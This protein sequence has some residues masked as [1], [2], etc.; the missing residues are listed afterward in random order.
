VTPLE[1]A[2]AGIACP[3]CGV[4]TP[5]EARFCPACGERLLGGGDDERRVVT[6]LFADLVESTR[7]VESLDPEAARDLLNE[8]FRRLAAEIRRCGGTLE[9]FVGDAIL[10]VFGFPTGHDDDAARAVR[11]SLAM[12]DIVK[13]AETA[14]GNLPLQLRIG[15][16]TGEVAAGRWSGDLRVTGPAVHTAARI[17]Q[18]AKPDQILLSARTLRA[19]RDIVEVGRPESLTVRGQGQ[20]VE[21]AEVL[22]LTPAE[23][24]SDPMVGREADLAGLIGA[25]DHAAHHN[26]LVLLVG[27]AG[28]G[29]STL[30]RAVAAEVGDRVHVLW[31]RCLPDWQSLPFWPIRE[32]LATAAGMAATE[33]AEVLTAAVGRLVADTWPDGSAA[34]ATAEALCRLAGLDPDDPDPPAQSGLGSSRE[35]AAAMAGVLCGLAGR[36]RVLV[37]LEDLHWATSDLLE[38]ASTL[39]GDGCR[40]QG[41]L[42]YLGISRP[43]LLGLPAWLLRT[44][45]QRIDLEP[46]G[47]EPAGEL[48]GSVLGADAAPELAGQ[49]FEASRGNPLFVKELAL[50]LREAGP[51]EP[52]QSS[53]PIPDSLQALVAARL[54]RLPPSAKRVLCRAA[55]VGKWFSHAALA[56]MAQ[57]GDGRLDSD[58]DR[59]VQEGLIERLPERLAGGQERFAFHHALFREVAYGLLPKA[60]RSELHRRLADWLAGAPDEE[61]SLPEV[62]ASHLVQ[63]VRLAGEVRAPSAEDRELA[64]RAVAACQRAARRLRDQEAL[65]AAALVLDDALDLGDLARTDPEQRAELRLERGTVRGGLG[66]L[67]GALADLGAATGAERTVVRARAWIE[68]SDLHA[69]FERFAESAAAA[70]RALVESAEAGDPALV[71]Q[72]TRVKAYVPYF[73]GDLAEAGRLLGEALA[74]ARRAGQARVVIDLRVTLLPLR[75]YLATPLD[76]LREEAV[77]LAAD[78]RSAGRRSAEAAAHVTLGEVA[79]LQDDLEAA[80]RHLADGNRLSLEVGLIRKRLWSLLGLVQ[81]AIA[82]GQPEA[83]LRTAE[84]AIALTTRPDGTADVEAELH[85]A[86]AF[87]AGDDLEAAAGAI[88]RGWAVLQ[89][90]DVFSRARLHRT[91]ARLAVAAGDPAG[92]VVL[93]ERS[94]AA[95]DTTGFR[96]DSLYSLIDLA[97]ALRLVGRADEADATAK[98]ALDQATTMG[99]HALVRRLEAADPPAEA[100]REGG[101][102]R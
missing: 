33:P 81:V 85:L 96:L 61:P 75:M 97:S 74:H 12:R 27:E 53:L 73:A 80:E 70:D 39:V 43:D 98:R 76:L 22:G 59:L 82:R 14:L 36:E 13:T 11:A 91:E 71:A 57:S 79:W 25:L 62:L 100:G 88:G 18:A 30:A 32:V 23:P 49:V 69:M 37:V 58:L 17:Q 40:A 35:L 63:A 56:A 66:D 50:A 21:V 47:Q 60:G 44:G 45:T 95:L 10:A 7:L 2:S 16:D 52:G 29:K 38:L 31:G 90:V 51:A 78:A 86:E 72:A 20:P 83:A 65:A 46:L 4:G 9:K 48:L 6:V 87:L 92:A 101:G 89:E 15:L 64:A 34:P 54:D 28:V 94:L 3:A 41:Q 84:E 19:A 68:L 26:R 67:A 102:R 77:A 1:A 5:A 93:L 8:T 24:A 42:A 55:V 99:A